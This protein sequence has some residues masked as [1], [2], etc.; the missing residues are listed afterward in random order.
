MGQLVSGVGLIA[1]NAGVVGSNEGELPAKVNSAFRSKIPRG[2]GGKR[3]HQ[4]A[5]FLA[6][7]EEERVGA[8]SSARS[9]IGPDVRGRCAQ[10][11]GAESIENCRVSGKEA[12]VSGPRG[13]IVIAQKDA[14]VV[15][16][17]I[18]P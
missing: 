3:V 2:S 1:W 12:R 13:G 7:L 18:L 5:G 15:G 10:I 6:G 9:G 8:V 16:E 17:E 4:S 11:G 14:R